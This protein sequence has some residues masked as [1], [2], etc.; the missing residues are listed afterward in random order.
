MK[1]RSFL[2]TSLALGGAM[3]AYPGSAMAKRRAEPIIRENGKYDLLLKGGN[4]MDPANGMNAD[5]T[6]VAVADGKIAAV[7]RNIP[8]EQ[9]KL[10]IDASD[11]HVTPGFIDIHAHIFYTDD[12]PNYRWVIADDIC[13]PSGVTTVVDPG[14]SGAGTF[15][16]LLKII[17]RSK[18]RTL[19]LINN[20]Y[21]GMDEGEQ[22]PR[23]FKVDEM[24][25]TAREHPDVVVG[26]KTAHYWSGRPY[27]D[28]HTPWAAVDA[29]MEA[30]RAMD[31]PGMFDF[32]PR[33]PSD[34]HPARSYRGLILEKTRAGDI[35][36]H[37]F[38]PHIPVLGEDGKVNPDIFKAQEKGFI[39]DVGHG[40]GSFVWKWAVPS[41]EQGYLPDTIST[42][43]HSHNTC[44]PVINMAFVMSKFLCMGLT[45]EQ[46]IERSTIR[47]AKVINQSDLG[48]LTV[49]NPADIALFEVLKG[50]FSFVDV[51]GGKNYGDKMIHN[52]MTVA[53]GRV[54]FDPYGL[55]LP[56]WEDV[57]K[58]SRYW[59]W[60]RQMW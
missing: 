50:D 20:S 10:V 37:C 45:L 52:I 32:S 2:G 5:R 17:E 19:A 22:D 3:A 12:P 6:D 55:S 28:L 53:G 21:T 60:P 23:L 34:G 40:A 15:P 9:A 27:D 48:A 8:S 44:G 11:L 14:S 43:L 24:I 31:L 38:A 29:V 49:G 54:G 33:P 36:T 30:G 1:R 16:E 59:Q 18:T 7:D 41:I 58:D 4:V 35:H 57:P 51:R 39:F 25:R 26:F 47:P 42:D 46:V 13:W 56:Y